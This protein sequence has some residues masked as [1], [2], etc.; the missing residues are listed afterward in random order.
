MRTHFRCV[1]KHREEEHHCLW[2]TNDVDGVV[3][4]GSRIACFRTEAAAIEFAAQQSLL[5]DDALPHRY[6][7]DA[8]AAWAARPHDRGIDCVAFLNFWN[9][10]TDMLTSIE[11]HPLTKRMSSSSVSYDKLFWGNNLS[12]VTP[13]GQRFHP[14]WSE[15]Q[16]S[17]IADL[18]RAAV[19]AF[20]QLREWVA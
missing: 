8:I 12:A 17:E 7:F 15:E 20:D 11:G 18:F 5:V 10:L 4:R 14:E 3:T 19:A 16:L 6:D 9:L 13:P 2:F 1:C